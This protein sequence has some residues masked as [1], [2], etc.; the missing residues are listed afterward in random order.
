MSH[1]VS[2]MKTNIA[3][4]G[5]REWWCGGS[6]AVL[7]RGEKKAFQIKWEP[8]PL[9]GKGCPPQEQQSPQHPDCG[10]EIP[11]PRCAG[12]RSRA[13]NAPCDP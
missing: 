12:P 8:C 1:V 5:E 9:W 11:F 6:V 10:V 4:L 13:G 3:G 7:Y 2:A